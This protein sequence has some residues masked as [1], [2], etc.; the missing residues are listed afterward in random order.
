[1]GTYYTKRVRSLLTAY[2]INH[3]A[4]VG[5]TIEAGLILKEMEARSNVSSVLI[6]C[7]R[8]LVAERKWV[9]EMKRFDE[10]FTQLDGRELAEAI[11]ETKRDGAHS[12]G[13]S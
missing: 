1:M 10:N 8:P 3:P 2:Q 7:P 11:S 12:Y 5:K 6:I 9:L 13:R 4:S